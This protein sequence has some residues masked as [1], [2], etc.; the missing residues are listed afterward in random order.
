MD[1]VAPAQFN[2]Y[3]AGPSHV[4]EELQQSPV[5]IAVQ[6][7]MVRHMH[8]ISVS[9]DRQFLRTW[10]R[11]LQQLLAQKNSRLLKF[12]MTSNTE[13]GADEFSKRATEVLAKYS[14]PTWNFA[15]SIRDV[16]LSTDMSAAASVVEEELGANPCQ[17]EQTLK[18][19][20]SAYIAAGARFCDV[21]ERLQNKFKRL[22]IAASCIDQLANLDPVAAS[23]GLTE[24][25][26][27]YLNMVFDKINIESDYTELIEQYKRFAILRN[28]VSLHGFQQ[29][30][31]PTC[32]ICM[33]KE[34]TQAL[35]PCGHTFCDDCCRQQ[36]TT[37]YICRVQV[38]DRLRLF[39]S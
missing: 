6:N 38:R 29:T 22:D 37:C 17:L 18:K 24:S 13:E 28:L 23:T 1:N 5:R 2:E 20:V 7:I 19:T 35:N 36:M 21:E 15:S 12:I 33:A 25:A 34:V 26:T 16:A 8:E 39:F 3:D 10:R 30:A 11:E 4:V 32:T 9:D 14:K 31:T 27:A